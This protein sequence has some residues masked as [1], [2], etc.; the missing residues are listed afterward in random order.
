MISACPHLIQW[1]KM[2]QP[3]RTRR[4]RRGN[5]GKVFTYYNKNGAIEKSLRVLCVSS[6]TSVVKK[7][8]R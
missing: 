3:L 4:S 1:W 7:I 8:N 2:D 6:V 5:R